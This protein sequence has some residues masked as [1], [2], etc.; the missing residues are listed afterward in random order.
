M[1]RD[2][3][4]TL[5]KQGV[6]SETKWPYIISKFRVKPTPACYKMPRIIKLLLI[7][8]LSRWMKCA[9]A[10]LMAFRL[11]LVLRLYE[12]FE[13]QAVAKTGIVNMPGQGEKSLVDMLFL[14]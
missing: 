11:S 7:A 1:I 9:H 10:W 12:S 6:C 14:P 3:I 13:S 2:G 8:E 4:K 5:A